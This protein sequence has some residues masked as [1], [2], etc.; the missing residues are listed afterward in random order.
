MG[1]YAKKIKE[2]EKDATKLLSMV[3]DKHTALRLFAQYTLHKLLYLLGSEVMYCFHETAFGRWGEWQ[4]PLSIRIDNMVESFL[5][6]LTCRDSIPLDSLLIAYIAIVQ[7][8]LGLMDAHTQAMTDFVLT[9]SQAIW[10]TEK[11]FS[12]S[13]TEPTYHLLATLCNLFRLKK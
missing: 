9:M 12:F 7:G 2:N 13:K 11:G 8:G 3:S 10:Y 4:G 5:S 6:K 1:F